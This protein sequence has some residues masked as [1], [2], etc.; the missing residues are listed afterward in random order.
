MFPM[1]IGASYTCSKTIKIDGVV[2]FVAGKSYVLK[3]LRAGQGEIELSFLIQGTKEEFSYQAMST[4]A[5]FRRVLAAL[6]ES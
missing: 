4:D 1:K 5:D 3:D 6:I 2:W